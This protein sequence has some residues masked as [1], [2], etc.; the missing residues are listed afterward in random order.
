MIEIE[1]FKKLIDD[2]LLILGMATVCYGVFLIYIPAGYIATG[3]S[4][5]VVSYLVAKIVARNGSEG[6]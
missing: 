1:V 6:R 4:L 2:I 3:A 5:I